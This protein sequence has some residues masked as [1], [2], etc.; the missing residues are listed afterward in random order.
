MLIAQRKQAQ[1]ARGHPLE[2]S[3]RDILSHSDRMASGSPS[4]SPVAPS[5]TTQFSLLRSAVTSPPLSFVSPRIH[6][7][8][9]PR[10]YTS[11]E[12]VYNRFKQRELQH[13]TEVTGHPASYDRFSPTIAFPARFDTVPGPVASGIAQHTTHSSQPLSSRAMTPNPNMHTHARKVLTHLSKLVH[14]LDR[15]LEVVT[16]EHE[17]HRHRLERQRQEKRKRRMAA[18]NR[19]MAMQEHRERSESQLQASPVPPLP[20]A[21]LPS[22][23]ISTSHITDTTLA[24]LNYTPAHTARS[25]RQPSPPSLVTTAAATAPTFL[26]DAE[27]DAHAL[28]NLTPAQRRQIGFKS[29]QRQS[30]DTRHTQ[31]MHD[32]EQIGDE[33]E[34]HVDALLRGDTS[35]PDHDSDASN[36]ESSD[37]ACPH[38]RS[39]SNHSITSSSESDSSS[40]SS[41]ALPSSI[42]YTTEMVRECE[43]SIA[44]WTH[45]LRQQWE[46]CNR[47]I[48]R[49]ANTHASIHAHFHTRS[50]PRNQL[51][52][53]QAAVAQA[54]VD[55]DAAAATDALHADLISVL[56]DLSAKYLTL[57]KLAMQHRPT[58][59]RRRQR[60]R[61]SDE[62]R[63]RADDSEDDTDDPAPVHHALPTLMESIWKALMLSIEVALSL[64]GGLYRASPPPLNRRSSHSVQSTMEEPHEQPH[65]PQTSDADQSTLD[66]SPIPYD[67]ANKSTALVPSSNPSSIAAASSSSTTMMP[68]SMS[69]PASS[70][71]SLTFDPTNSKHLSLLHSAVSNY[72]H[73]LA[74]LQHDKGGD[75][76]NQGADGKLSVHVGAA[77]L[78]SASDIVNALNI[79]SMEG[80]LH[81]TGLY[82]VGLMLQRD[83][84]LASSERLLRENEHLKISLK[85]ARDRVAELESNQERS[86]RALA[87]GAHNSLADALD[88]LEEHLDEVADG[89]ASQLEALKQ[90]HQFGNECVQAHASSTAAAVEAAQARK[91]AKEM[92]SRFQM[93]E[94]QIEEERRQELEEK[95]GVEFAHAIARMKARQVL[96]RELD[97]LSSLTDVEVTQKLAAIDDVDTLRHMCYHLIYTKVKRSYLNEMPSA[98]AKRLA[99]ERTPKLIQSILARNPLNINMN[100]GGDG[101]DGSQLKLL[102]AKSVARIILEIYASKAVTDEMEAR[103]RGMGGTGMAIGVNAIA[104]MHTGSPSPGSLATSPDALIPPHLLR[105]RG[106][107]MHGYTY[108]FFLHRFGLKAMAEASFAELLRSIMLLLKLPTFPIN[109]MLKPNK[110]QQKNKK[111][112][113]S[114]IE[115]FLSLN[116]DSLSDRSI[117]ARLK[118]FAHLTHLYVADPFSV[119]AADFVVGLFKLVAEA[120]AHSNAIMK[121]A[122]GTGAAVNLAGGV[123]VPT[124]GGVGNGGGNAAGAAHTVT[125]N[126]RVHKAATPL[127]PRTLLRDIEQASIPMHALIRN[128]GSARMMKHHAAE[129]DEEDVAHADNSVKDVP[130]GNLSLYIPLSIAWECVAHAFRHLGYTDDS[131]D[132]ALR[133]IDAAA[134]YPAMYMPSPST[135][136]TH[137]KK[138]PGSA[139]AAASPSRP[140]SSS[141]RRNKA[142]HSP[143]AEVDPHRTRRITLLKQVIVRQM[144][145]MAGSASNL[146]F[147]KFDT[148]KS[149]ILTLSKLRNMI[150]MDEETATQLAWMMDHAQ[151]Q[152]HTSNVSTIKSPTMRSTATAIAPLTLTLADFQ[153]CL[154]NPDY[155]LCVSLDIVLDV[156]ANGWVRDHQRVTEH[157]Q[158]CCESVDASRKG[159]L[160]FVEFYLMLQ[161]MEAT[162]NNNSVASSGSRVSSLSP[163]ASSFSPR[164]PLSP[165]GGGLRMSRAAASRLFKEGLDAD[166]RIQQLQQHA[167]EI[168][169]NKNKKRGKKR[170]ATPPPAPPPPLEPLPPMPP[171]PYSLDSDV[172]GAMDVKDGGSHGLS[173]STDSAGSAVTA[174]STSNTVESSSSVVSYASPSSSTPASPISKP[175]FI[176][177][178]S[179]TIRDTDFLSFD[180][181]VALMRK[182]RLGLAPRKHYHEFRAFIRRYRKERQNGQKEQQDGGVIGNQQRSDGEQHK[183][184]E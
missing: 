14:H 130:T 63:S 123:L 16:L 176:R 6:R 146:A 144:V 35:A 181:C 156:A 112:Q 58:R 168:S 138:R 105:R 157:F 22:S 42:V 61:S 38:R 120:C 133:R 20:L 101:G 148:D 150:P 166:R 158:Q 164:S 84:L 57:I 111:H 92:A 104:A 147:E 3:D 118:L 174:P 184:F 143:N 29:R 100:S 78:A 141:G 27:M 179:S 161:K 36:S 121:H 79:R 97:S 48:Q 9:T 134:V 108:F 88:D 154:H 74:L 177:A 153:Q 160:N 51:N 40:S 19:Q 162:Q 62:R 26:T 183:A 163:S 95:H 17:E 2:Q 155:R 106:Y 136:A 47:T 41:H 103:E 30:D 171:P 13:T 98:R 89:Q 45:F 172:D 49:T 39:R 122:P 180:T 159:L 175:R 82:S 151:P 76:M 68:S 25:H 15:N 10:T 65:H 124:G 119:E 23:S 70:P 182:H 86:I 77:A 18:R 32:A 96:D 135:T 109:N 8:R 46:A 60:H 107:T 44:A 178:P 116:S 66:P 59:R 94:T 165:A 80:G 99:K 21:S 67:P 132:D 72:E 125:S 139:N 31:R 169:S 128:R 50:S 90:L 4:T 53:Q 110:K 81:D 149:G 137:P 126:G 55:A 28:A 11:H 64:G 54:H 34:Q 87:Q 117:R 83:S 102:P 71:S 52:Q 170:T 5:S 142:S 56:D 43:E 113:S 73:N 131:L 24:L 91:E 115:S 140:P 75:G 85:A 93:K 145:R 127:D 12:E 167:D 37:H 33:K 7:P 152:P 129:G 173:F 114:H 1:Y 69:T